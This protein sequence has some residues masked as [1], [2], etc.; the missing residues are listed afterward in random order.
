MTESTKMADS[1]AESHTPENNKRQLVSESECEPAKKL[2]AGIDKAPIKKK[3]K[4]AMLLGYSGTGY[5]G[6]Q[7]NFGKETVEGNLISALLKADMITQDE[8]ERVQSFQFQ[9]AARTDK[10]VSAVRQV[11]SLKL[12]KYL[13]SSFM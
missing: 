11:V 2:Y 5:Y 12:R 9:R 7:R 1:L 6:M 4:V 3:R 8:S 13:L 10:N